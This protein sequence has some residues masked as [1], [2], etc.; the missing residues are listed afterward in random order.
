MSSTINYNVWLENT[1][2][3]YALIVNV[4][5]TSDRWSRHDRQHCG[6]YKYGNGMENIKLL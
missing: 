5:E 1:I 6:E 3:K 4:D 2:V